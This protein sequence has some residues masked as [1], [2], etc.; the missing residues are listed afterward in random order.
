MV[1]VSRL[2]L[3]T[4]MNR[5]RQ[6]RV[7]ELAKTGNFRK[8]PAE[9]TALPTPIRNIIILYHPSFVLPSIRD[10]PKILYS[11]M[12]S[13]YKNARK[14]TESEKQISTCERTERPSPMWDLESNLN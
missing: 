13:H 2:L 11:C 12:Q 8:G 3:T 4:Y 14:N 10:N 1:L 6:I 5:L 9:P 7:P